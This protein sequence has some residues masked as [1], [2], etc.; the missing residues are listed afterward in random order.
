MLPKCSKKIELYQPIGTATTAQQK[1]DSFSRCPR[2]SYFFSEINQFSRTEEKLL[3]HLLGTITHQMFL[4]VHVCMRLLQRR[5]VS[6]YAP[7]KLGNIRVIF[8]NFQKIPRLA[9]NI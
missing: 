1:L 7:S 3:S 4:L 2:C 5:L 6:E 8:P 9:K